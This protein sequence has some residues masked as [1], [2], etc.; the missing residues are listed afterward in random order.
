[1]STRVADLLTQCRECS[2]SGRLE[3]AAE[4]CHQVLALEPDNAAAHFELGIIA[5]KMDQYDAARNYLS[6]AV[7][8]DGDQWAFHH[9]LGHVCRHLGDLPLAVRCFRRA[10]ALNPACFEAFRDL[11]QVLIQQKN[12]ATAADMLRKAVSIRPDAP[13]AQI[14]LALTLDQLGNSIEAAG[15]FSRLAAS[16]PDVP[17]LHYNLGVVLAKVGE[18]DRAISSYRK[19]ITGRPDYAVAYNNLGTILTAVGDCEGAIACYRR[20]LL[21]QPDDAQARSN[22][23]MTLNYL[24]G[25]SQSEIYAETLQFEAKHAGRFSPY[26]LDFRNSR[27]RQRVLK[28]GYVSSEFKVHSVAHFV[29]KLIAAHRRDR[30]EVFCYA[31]VTNPD[32][33]THEIQAKADH[34][35]SIIGMPDESVVE[36]IR[37]DQI[38]ILVDLSGHTADNRLLVF[39][40]RPAPVQVS[41]LGYPNTTGMRAMD[42]RLTD[43]IA[44]PTGDADRLHSEK[45]I[46]LRHGF[47]CYQTD[48]PRRTIGDPPCLGQGHITYG[49]FNNFPKITP[50]VMRSWSAILKLTPDSR[51]ILKSRAMFDEQ[52]R[53]RCLNAF[54]EQGIR[55][56]RLDLLALTATREEHLETY[57]R[58]DIGLDT[59]PYNGTTTTCEA[60]WMGVPVITLRGDRHAGRVGAS[61]M[62]H[63]GLPELIA[64]NET[65]YVNLAQQLASDTARLSTFR[66]GLRTQMLQSPLMNVPLFTE[67]LEQAYRQMW[68]RWCNEG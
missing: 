39:A 8:L 20:A 12:L 57:A 40:C 42:Y 19:A 5:L 64:E 43:A 2:Q 55:P 25:T 37:A 9:A 65:G 24:P 62:H 46:R 27:E 67:S 34:W 6:R 29:R 16:R 15:I 4:K 11:G 1:M 54:G 53:L 7:T 60:L 58:V 50:D 23:L 14:S 26:R 10:I 66:H 3:T 61:I 35:L 41:W 28:I 22:L 18:F 38:D 44:D 45:L 56:D 68:I 59:Y 30:V 63:A 13:N 32:E 49:S 36:R 47:L 21:H 51:L 33:M 17:E 48:E 31:N 52:T